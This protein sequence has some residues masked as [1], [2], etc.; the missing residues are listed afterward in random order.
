MKSA[1]T[2]GKE[3]GNIMAKEP[4]WNAEKLLQQKGECAEVNSTGTQE[5]D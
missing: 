4:T 5:K 1:S 3:K 2:F